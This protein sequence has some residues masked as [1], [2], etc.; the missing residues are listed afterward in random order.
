MINE[1]IDRFQH[2]FPGNK[3]GIRIFF[4]PGRVNL[5]GEHTDY[6][7]GYV[8]PTAITI[9]TF[10]AIKERTDSEFH[11]VSENF[12]D[13]PVS[14][15]KDDLAYRDTDSW[16]NYPK[17]LIAMLLSKGAEIKGADIYYNGTIPNGA[18]LSSSAS[19][20]MVTAYGLSKLN[21]IDLSIEKL[22]LMSQAVENQYI[23]VNSGIMDQFAVGM[24]K[25]DHA[26]FLDCSTYDYEQIS[27]NLDTYRLVITN[28]NKSR[29]LADSKYNERRAECEEGLKRIREIYPEKNSLSELSS[30]EF[31]KACELIKD[32]TLVRRIRHVVKENERVKLSKNLLFRGELELFGELMRES[33]ESLRDDYEVTGQE[34]DALFDI[35]K[36]VEGCIG[37]RMTGAG[38]G[39]CT[40]S[41]VK[42]DAVAAFKETVSNLYLKETGIKPSFYICNSGGGV[43]ELKGAAV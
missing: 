16:G 38:F 9:G 4:A 5:I 8:F 3:D 28:T 7:D 18:G 26:L 23:G 27:L 15:N 32:E 34:L 22:A 31:A 13:Q 36:E 20:S 37:T 10:M 29:G 14:F 40:I 24:C 35:Q 30:E 41:I 2:Y 43:K 17:G 19:I 21:Q 6:N 25:E 33:H 39:G 11:L 12:P 42:E 1:V